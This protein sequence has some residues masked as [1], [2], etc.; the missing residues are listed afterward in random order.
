MIAKTWCTEPLLFS[1]RCRIHLV[2]LFSLLCFLRTKK[3]NNYNGVQNF[4][5]M[6]HVTRCI[7]NSGSICPHKDIVKADFQCYFISESLKPLLTYCGLE[8]CSLISRNIPQYHVQR[9]TG[10]IGKSIFRT[11]TL[12]PPSF[13]M[14]RRSKSLQYRGFVCE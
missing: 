14:G 1:Y 7:Y 11:N 12:I 3:R 9:I 13:Y 6:G 4:P 5:A 10:H 2:H 8:F